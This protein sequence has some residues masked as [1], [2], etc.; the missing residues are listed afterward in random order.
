MKYLFVVPSGKSVVILPVVVHADCPYAS[1]DIT[2]VPLGIAI[3]V[4]QH[5]SVEDKVSYLQV[6][7]HRWGSSLGFL[8]GCDSQQNF[9][10]SEARG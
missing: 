8:R 3:I 1:A 10:C 9:R 6:Q 4:S 2:F 5:R 7:L